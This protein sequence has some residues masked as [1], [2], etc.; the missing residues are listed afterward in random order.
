[1]VT[2]GS[3]GSAREMLMAAGGEA[4]LESGAKVE[5]WKRWVWIGL[6]LPQIPG[7]RHSGHFP[8]FQALATQT[9][10][11]RIYPSSYAKAKTASWPLGA[12]LDSCSH[13]DPGRSC[14]AARKYMPATVANCLALPAPCGH[15]GIGNGPIASG[16]LKACGFAL[17]RDNIASI[18]TSLALSP[19]ALAISTTLSSPHDASPTIRCD[20]TANEAR[21]RGAPSSSDTRSLQRCVE[22]S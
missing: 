21:L 6:A 15:Q 4:Q 9:R 20:R 2:T 11:N 7:K 1:M 16:Q 13:R 22:A 10:L 3:T 5:T 18:T 12:A 14:D 19:P 8:F 17:V